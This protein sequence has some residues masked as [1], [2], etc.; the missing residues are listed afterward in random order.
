MRLAEELQSKGRIARKLAA[1]SMFEE[2]DDSLYELTG[3]AL[4]LGKVR[5]LTLVSVCFAVQGF[6]PRLRSPS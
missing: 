2:V 6:S 5:V 3:E 1:V 4:G